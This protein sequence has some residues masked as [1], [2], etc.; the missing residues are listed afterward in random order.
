MSETIWDKNIPDENIQGFLS[1]YLFLSPVQFSIIQSRIAEYEE[2]FWILCD[3]FDVTEILKNRGYQVLSIPSSIEEGV[4]WIKEEVES[5]LEASWRNYASNHLQKSW[6]KGEQLEIE[7]AVKKLVDIFLWTIHDEDEDSQ[8]Q[9]DFIRQA[10]S[11]KEDILQTSIYLNEAWIALIEESFKAFSNTSQF[12]RRLFF[13]LID[14]LPSGFWE[15]V[16]NYSKTLLSELNA[17]LYPKDFL[18][19]K[20][21]LEKLV[22]VV[23]YF[24]SVSV[25]QDHPDCQKEQELLRK[26][27]E[28][29]TLP[30][31][32]SMRGFLDKEEND[33]LSLPREEH[34]ALVTREVIIEGIFQLYRTSPEVTHTLKWREYM[35]DRL[36]QQ[37]IRSYDFDDFFSPIYGVRYNREEE[38]YYITPM[39]DWKTSKWRE[40][41]R[42]TALSVIGMISD[43]EAF[44]TDDE[45]QRLESFKKDRIVEIQRRKDLKK[46]RII[47]QRA[48]KKEGRESSPEKAFK[49]MF[50][51]IIH[52]FE[53]SK[54]NIRRVIE[55]I[56]WDK[57]SEVV[58]LAK[59]HNISAIDMVQHQLQ[60]MGKNINNEPKWHDKQRISWQVVASVLAEIIDIKE[61]ILPAY[62]LWNSK[63]S[64]LAIILMKWD[65]AETMNH[66][67][68]NIYTRV[69]DNYIENYRRVDGKSHNHLIDRISN[70][71]WNKDDIFDNDRNL[72][73]RIRKRKNLYNDTKAV[74]AW[75][76][77][78][79]WKRVS[80][81]RDT[82]WSEIKRSKLKKGAIL[83]WF[84]E[85]AAH[86]DRQLVQLNALKNAWRD[87]LDEEKQ[88]KYDDITQEMDEIEKTKA[89]ERV[90]ELLEDWFFW[91][92]VELFSG[93]GIGASNL[94]KYSSLRNQIGLLEKEEDTLNVSLKI[95]QV[96]ETKS[97]ISRLRNV[98]ERNFVLSKEQ[99]EQLDEKIKTP[100]TDFMFGKNVF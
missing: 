53:D 51:N 83:K 54:S 55:G 91:E 62:L 100:R 23:S 12:H 60:E 97:E 1:Q 48:R 87:N 49:Y 9:Y 37:Y 73:K 41:I 68:D 15:I 4:E 43:W 14:E 98:Y 58:R 28:G 65:R 35:K 82:I 26:H 39:W 19:L 56:K 59:L 92:Q 71:W 70:E 86:C 13:N 7:N 22:K 76:L 25:F 72:D 84:D 16:F 81:L 74:P 88:Q 29:Y 11:Q 10:F 42:N 32:D 99:R 47:E 96:E 89:F 40:E 45:K 61:P 24:D 33:F 52:K 69:V 3:A 38:D 79:D 95:Q 77:T 75:W 36:E 8:L 18:L 66:L 34:V 50:W 31:I 2:E 78:P 21:F 93:G 6:S 63:S 44:L 30:L 17:N 57:R 5:N 46:E 27:I 90:K 67:P 20:N 64:E 80:I 94:E 85:L